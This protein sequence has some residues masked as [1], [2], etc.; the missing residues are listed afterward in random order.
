MKPNAS[1]VATGA[2]KILVS[3][4]HETRLA[5]FPFRNVP[6]FS[7]AFALDAQPDLNVE[8]QYLAKTW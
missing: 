1:V 8:H 3:T 6:L 7:P 2:V 5:R 4:E